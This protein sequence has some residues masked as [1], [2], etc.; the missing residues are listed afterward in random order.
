MAHKT[1]TIS[2][3]AYD[4]LKA[5]KLQSESF[6][7]VIL[8][9]AGRRKRASELLAWV[10]DQRDHSDLADALEEVYQQ[11]DLVTLRD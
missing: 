11:R 6:T 10:K 2:E 5:L 4:A 1:I 8:R 9:I 3:E 7:E